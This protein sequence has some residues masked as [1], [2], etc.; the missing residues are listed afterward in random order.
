MTI[1]TFQSLFTSLASIVAR[2]GARSLQVLDTQQGPAAETVYSRLGWQRA[3][4]IADFAATASGKL[5]PT[6]FYFM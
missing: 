3:G 2:A 5:T 4:T 1:S 6:V